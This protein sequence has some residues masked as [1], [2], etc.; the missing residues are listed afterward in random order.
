MPLS[1]IR[2]A[3]LIL[4]AAA[5]PAFGADSALS[6]KNAYV[7][8]AP[9]GA[10]A[11]AAFLTI[12][13]AGDSPRRLVGA[14]SPVAASAELHT[15]LE[16]N[17][18]VKMRAVDSIEIPASGEMMLKPGGYHVMLKGL[19]VPLAEGELVPLV[20]SFDDGS[21]QKVDAPV[22]RQTVPAGDKGTQN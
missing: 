8:L 1:L 3:L 20:L 19:K 12:D 6:I 21:R 17:G 13:N 15:S 22:R 4:A 5:A 10:P 18:V 14:E 7:R 11:I 2:L 16:E 9:P